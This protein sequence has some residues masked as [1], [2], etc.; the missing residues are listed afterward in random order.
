MHLLQQF[1][2]G[3]I[4]FINNINSM[5][6][7]IRNSKQVKQVIDFTGIQ[8]GKIHPSDI[9]FVFEFDNK[10]LILG[11]VKRYNNPIPM[12]QQLLLERI[13][14]KW[15][16]YGIAIKVEHNFQNDDENIPLKECTV[17][18]KYTLDKR[19]EPVFPTNFKEFINNL[20]AE[21]N[22]KKCKF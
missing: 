2:V 10:F 3:C 18:R 8:N 12:G 14:D 22:C 19:W 21:W 13:I 15:G 5:D 7:L 1:G 20:G 9:D 6:S 16:E 11:E 4:K 17:T